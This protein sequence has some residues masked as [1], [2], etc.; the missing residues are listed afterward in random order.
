MSKRARRSGTDEDEA[1]RR[2]CSRARPGDQL[3]IPLQD[4]TSHTAGPEL[5]I[6]EPGEHASG[7]E[8]GREAINN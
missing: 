5:V 4:G 3:A 1:V 8:S 6:G 7:A 2:A